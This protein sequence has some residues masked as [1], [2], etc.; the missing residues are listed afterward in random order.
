MKYRGSRYL[1]PMI[2]ERKRAATVKV[3]AKLEAKGNQP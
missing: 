1:P 3:I 2:A